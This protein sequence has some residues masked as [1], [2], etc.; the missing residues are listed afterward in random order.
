[1]IE[2]IQ[3]RNVATYGPVIE[4]LTELKE[5][6]FVYGSNGTGETTISRVIADCGSH[7]DCSLGWRGGTS[8]DLL[9]CNRDFVE[10][11]FNQPDELKGIFTLGEK[12]KKTLDK[13]DTAKE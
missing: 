7:P 13:I 3:I 2:R 11:N 12:D 10:R 8:I 5:I 6:N 9:V 1:M 4:K